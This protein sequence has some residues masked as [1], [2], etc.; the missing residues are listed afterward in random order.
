[1]KD[2]NI[3]VHTLNQSETNLSKQIYNE[4]NDKYNTAL[5]TIGKLPKN[6]ELIMNQCST[7]TKSLHTP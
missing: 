6:I 2:L 7:T 3:Y 1:M 5:H 4:C